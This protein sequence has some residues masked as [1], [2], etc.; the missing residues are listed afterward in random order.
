MKQVRPLNVAIVGGGPGCKAIMDMIFAEKLSQLNMRLIGVASTD[1]KALGFLYAQEKGVYNTTDYRDLYKLEDLDMI[2]ELTGNEEMANEIYQT[3]PQHVRVMDHVAA[4]VFWDVFQVE[5]QRIAERLRSEELTKLAF[6]ELNQIFE[7]AADGMCIIDKSFDILRVNE[8]F[9]VLSGL[10][11]DD[12]VGMKCYEA[13]SGSHCHTTRCS[14]TR[15]IA[16]EQR[17]EMDTEKIDQDGR[18]L[19]CIVTATAFRDAE[20]E[21]IGVVEN[22]KDITPRKRAEAALLESEE[23]YSALVENSLTGVFIHQ[24][25]RYIFVNDRFAEM[26]GYDPEEMLGM[27]RT[28]L[29]HPDDRM[30]SV[31]IAAKRLKGEVV[32]QRYEIRRVTKGGEL[33]WCDMM[34]N[35]IDYAGE[36][37]IMGNILDIT[38]RK[39]AEEALRESEKRYRTVLEASPDPVVVY[40]MEGKVTFT[41]PAFT[42]VFGWTADELLGRKMSYVPDENWPE[43]QMMIDKVRVGDSFSDVESRRYTKQGNILDVSISAATYADHEGNPVGSVHVLRDIT[44]RRQAE[45]ALRESEEKYRALFDND[46]NSIFVLDQDSYIISDVNERT[47][48]VYGYK[49]NEL[50]GKSFKELGTNDYVEGV[51][52]ASGPK[53]RTLCSVY[54]KVEHERNNGKP[55]YVNVYACQG[56]HSEKYGVIVTTVDITESVAKEAQLMQAS[57]MST[58]GEMAAGVAHEI[59]NPIAIMLGFTEL[60]IDRVPKDSKEFQ[61]LKTIEKQGISCKKIVENLLVFSRVPEKDTAETDITSNLQKVVNMVKNTLLTKKVDLKTKI[62]QDLPKVRGDSHQLE[63]VYLNMISNAVAAMGDGG[64]LT[65][66]AHQSGDVIKIDFSDTGHGIPSRTIDKIFE[67]FFTTKKVG[68]GTGLGLYMSYG[69]VKKFG[70]EIQVTSRT[71]KAGLESGTTFTVTLPALT[72]GIQEA[73]TH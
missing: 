46:P 72:P 4:R 34:A 19:P 9:S 27:D 50:I 60:L 11:K 55:F 48:Q 63:Q 35:R 32:P 45:T 17:V 59:N 25:G 2:I 47:L 71:K 8:T 54:P 39:R 5:E 68:E 49:R 14:L 64:V 66:S 41:N 65:I 44:Q 31:Q 70:G 15:I 42:K 24:G 62:N 69:I 36:P 73:T 13:F 18:K 53:T 28:L 38:E 20:G 23:K 37:A 12:A 22:V 16:G 43:T 1:P 3:K 52:A 61:M 7:T 30:T 33:L 21:L 40:D 10:S 51:L 6:A 57:K 56:K 58:L 29:V 67:P 26:H